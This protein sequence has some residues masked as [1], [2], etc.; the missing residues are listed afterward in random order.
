MSRFSPPGLRGSHGGQGFATTPRIGT[1]AEPIGAAARVVVIGG[2]V[3]IVTGAALAIGHLV[4]PGIGWAVAGV[5]VAVVLS[6]A[7]YR[8][9]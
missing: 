5:A 2:C 3:A 1:P 6:A 4:H 8:F 9:G 7:A